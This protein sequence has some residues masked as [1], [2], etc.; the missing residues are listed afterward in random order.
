MVVLKKYFKSEII[1]EFYNSGPVFTKGL[2]QVLDLNVQ[3]NC[4]KFKPK[5]WLSSF[6]NTSPGLLLSKRKL[7]KHAYFFYRL[8]LVCMCGENGNC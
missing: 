4:I 7:Q 6:I 1:Q 5:N 8:C 2:S 3:Y